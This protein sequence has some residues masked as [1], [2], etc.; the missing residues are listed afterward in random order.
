MAHG[1][2]GGQRLALH[3]AAELVKHPAS[4]MQIRGVRCMSQCKRPCVAALSAPDAFSYLFGDLEP[5]NPTHV[6]ALFDL[7]ERY[8]ASEEGFVERTARPEAL[9]ANILGRLPPLN[10]RSVLVSELGLPQE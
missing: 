3:V 6:A 8:A 7:A 9:R 4:P 1:V 2:R 10:S 5:D